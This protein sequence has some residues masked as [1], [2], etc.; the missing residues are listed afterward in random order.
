MHGERSY[1]RLAS[2]AGQVNH[3]LD[4]K[5]RGIPIG[6]SRGA[7]TSDDSGIATN[8][9]ESTMTIRTQA[10]FDALPE[11]AQSYIYTLLYHNGFWPEDDYTEIERWYGADVSSFTVESYRSI[12]DDCATFLEKLAKIECVRAVWDDIDHD[13]LGYALYMGR[14]GTGIEKDFGS[15]EVNAAMHEAAYEMGEAFAE[16]GWW[17]RISHT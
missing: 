12:V 3:E 10:L 9:M 1:G 6:L 11:I 7:V 13:L 14:M 8:P 4:S 5:S 16:V 2:E 15:D 17:R